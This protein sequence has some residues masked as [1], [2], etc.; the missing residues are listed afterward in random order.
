MS[1]RF[2]RFADFAPDDVEW[3]Q[4]EA[5]LLESYVGEWL[6]AVVRV[7][8]GRVRVEAPVTGAESAVRVLRD[9]RIGGACA[10]R[11]DGWR[12][13]GGGFAAAVVAADAA[14]HLRFPAAAARD[15]FVA[16]VSSCAATARVGS[17]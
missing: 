13:F 3:W 6:P 9:F 14:A 10:A 1:A 4:G 8:Q 16:A 17:G 15:A 7:R 5:G 12:L 11:A 2:H